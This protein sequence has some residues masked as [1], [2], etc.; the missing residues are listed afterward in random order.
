MERS[1]MTQVKRYLVSHKKKKLEKKV[2]CGL[3]AAVVFC[4]VYVLILPAVT[5]SNEVICGM[6]AHTH[7]ESCWAMTLVQP[8]P[9]L[10]CGAEQL[11]G[12][13]LH[14]HNEFCYDNDGNLICGLRE[15]ESHVHSADCYQEQRNLICEESQ[16][17]GH[18]HTDACY[19]MERGGL[20]CGQE[21][22]EGGHVH[23][24][25]CYTTTSKEVS[26]CNIAES[27]G[28]THT[29]ACYTQAAREVLACGQS[30]SEDELDEEGNVISAGHHHSGSCYETEYDTELSCGLAETT[31][32]Q[33]SAAC[34]ET[35]E[36]NV[37]TCGQT[38]SQNEG[39][40]H[41]DS[42][43]EWAKYLT[44]RQEERTSTHVH[45]DEC[46]EIT[47]ILCCGKQE[48]VPHT[49]SAVCDDED[50]RLICGMQEVVVHNHTSSC[51]HVP[52][53]DGEGEMART[54]ICG[55]EEHIHAESCYVDVIH[56]LDEEY[57]CG[58]TEHIHGDS[59]Y[60]EFGT[61]ICTITEHIHDENCLVPPE[62]EEPVPEGEGVV[63]LDH[64]Y[65]YETEDGMFAVTFYINGYAAVNRS[66]EAE[67]LRVSA[68]D[69][70]YVQPEDASG[71][72]LEMEEDSAPVP[73]AGLE[74]GIPVEDDAG[75]APEDSGLAP[76]AS[77]EEETGSSGQTDEGLN[78]GGDRA[79]TFPDAAVLDPESVEFH[80][81]ALP[82]SDG[83][84]KKLAAHTEEI[85]EDEDPLMLQVLTLYAMIDG[86]ELDLSECDILVEIAPTENLIGY[87]SEAQAVLLDENEDG[88]AEDG[89]GDISLQCVAF[90]D[91]METGEVV[92]LASAIL[93]QETVDGKGAASGSA[94]DHN[95]AMRGAAIMSFS[96]P[97]GSSRNVA[98]SVFQDVYPH[99]TVELYALREAPVKYTG[100]VSGMLPFINTD[101]GGEN[102][103]GNMPRNGGNDHSKKISLEIDEDSS[104]TADN[105]QPRYQVHFEPELTEMY[106]PELH[107]FN[108][109]L[110]MEEKTRLTAERMDSLKAKE[111]DVAADHYELK[112]IWVLPP[113]MDPALPE[114]GG[115]ARSNWICYMLSGTDR[116][117]AGTNQDIRYLT[118]DANKDGKVTLNDLYFTNNE[119]S[120]GENLIL[121]QDK[122]PAGESASENAG[123]PGEQVRH[124]TT[125]RL[126]YGP[127][128]GSHSNDAVLYDYN[129]T[130][131]PNDAATVQTA[132]AIKDEDGKVVEVGGV[133]INDPSNYLNNNGAKFAFGN[134]NTGVPYK[135]EKWMTGGVSNELNKL[136]EV[137][138]DSSRGC[139]FGMVTDYTVDGD[140]KFAS[141]IDAPNLFGNDGRVTKGKTTL[142]TYRLDFKRE[143]NTY[144]LTAVQGTNAKCL[145]MFNHPLAPSGMP[146]TDIWTNNFWPVDGID[147]SLRTDPKTGGTGGDVK[148]DNSAATENADDKGGFPAS[149]DSGVKR[150]NYFGMNFAVDFALPKEYIGPLEYYFY[151]DDDM[152]V[153][154]TDNQTHERTLVCDIGGIH[155]TVGE[156]VNLWD[157][158]PKE[159]RTATQ[160]YTL[161]FFYTERGASGSTCWMQYTVPNVANVPLDV[162]PDL[163]NPPLRIEKHV[164]GN[165]QPKDDLTYNF[166]LTLTNVN[167]NTSLI[168]MRY[169]Q[170]PERNDP[171]EAYK[172]FKIEGRNPLHFDLKNGEYLVVPELNGLV[173]YVVE[174]DSYEN[175]GCSTSIKVNGEV[176]NSGNQVSDVVG[177]GALVSYTNGYYLE[178]PE[179]GG[180]GTCWYTLGG[181]LLILAAGL[182]WYRKRPEGEGGAAG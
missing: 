114:E 14:T 76:P 173:E 70:L 45:M 30:E 13:V 168:A 36:E 135:S 78:T 21:E 99:Y 27:E 142:G 52:E 35:V 29:D 1:L 50:G 107:Q 120:T 175:I 8:Q 18:T 90:S 72:L 79:D 133:G 91:D 63:R 86:E 102:K 81:E 9:E 65:Q 150:N 140:V 66:G 82:E 25:A 47:E 174:E 161:T 92:E 100:E 126:V 39:H 46:Y 112:A 106:L 11:S 5:M 60:S 111:G 113:D 12:I 93:N 124:H 26:V 38:E 115:T 77:E 148:F 162:K 44:C 130:N 73:L 15:L 71:D 64:S 83:E 40:Q 171:G 22:G 127:V 80:V 17:L 67:T 57:L 55:K 159:G 19:A 151:G 178:L 28:H 61:L 33:H 6:E 48:L 157:Y 42:C 181:A 94:A 137:N 117:F 146:Y 154:L 31:G 177:S 152:W 10:I 54:L 95:T 131:G 167:E 172:S 20:I 2:L 37:L 180:N 134:A 164:E 119:S 156:Y 97:A 23:T 58:L 128:E 179:T 158:I 143:G 160:R 149:D 7:D 56:K 105:G 122:T 32:H 125:V 84:Y 69:L 41:S 144:T 51:V 101:N 85:S 49:H 139:T 74:D 62:P 136:N 53:T 147:A 176:Q 123:T 153:F 165:N 166:K 89:A 103:G 24:D 163:E 16:D 116:A 109:K 88:G 98:L 43:Y 145:D 87:M 169:S 155:R 108:P 96:L 141:G 182:L 34:Y 110:E 75:T 3:G 121:L 4:T 132:Q 104:G 59:C 170:D 129:I 138:R 68:D 118:E